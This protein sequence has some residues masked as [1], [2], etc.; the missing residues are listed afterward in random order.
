MTAHRRRQPKTSGSTS[1][2]R[3]PPPREWLPRASGSGRR[4]T[5]RGRLPHAPAQCPVAGL[6]PIGH[7]RRL[8]RLRHRHARDSGGAILGGRSILLRTGGGAGT[9]GA[10]LNRVRSSSS[11]SSRAGSG[12]ANNG[13]DSDADREPL[14]SG[15]SRVASSSTSSNAAATA[16]L[17]GA[18]TGGGGTAVRMTAVR[19]TS[20]ASGLMLRGAASTTKRARS[21]PIWTMSPGCN[22]CSLARAPLTKTPLRLPRSL[23]LTVLPE[24]TNS[25]CRRDSSESSWLISHAGSRPTTMRPT[26]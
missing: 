13:A 15:T 1:R 10:A 9:S 14:E 4:Q 11:S 25:A 19:S 23:T 2:G 16:G 3:G 12:R 24:V 8:P 21:G 22:V 6:P 17:N 20:M 18:G 5:C 7:H 26:R